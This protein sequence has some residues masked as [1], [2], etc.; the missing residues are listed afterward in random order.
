MMTLSVCHM[1]VEHNTYQ[2]ILKFSL[3][4]EYHTFTIKMELFKINPN[5]DQNLVKTFVKNCDDDP[6]NPNISSLISNKLEYTES[7]NLRQSE[8]L[9]YQFSEIPKMQNQEDPTRRFKITVGKLEMVLTFKNLVRVY[10]FFESFVYNYFILDAAYNIY[11]QQI[12]SHTPPKETMQSIDNSESREIEQ[13]ITEDENNNQNNQELITPKTENKNIVGTDKTK[14]TNGQ[15]NELDI[16]LSLALSKSLKSSAV[17]YIFSYYRYIN[18]DACKVEQDENGIMQVTIPKI[19]P[20]QYVFDKNYFLS[21]VE[22]CLDNEDFSTEKV[23]YVVRK[24]LAT[25]F[26]TN[27]SV[28]ENNICVMTTCYLLFIY[29][30]RYTAD[31]FPPEFKNKF[32]QFVESAHKQTQLFNYFVKYFP[33]LSGYRNKIQF[34]ITELNDQ[35][36]TENTDIITQASEEYKYL[37]SSSEEK[38]ANLVFDFIQDEKQKTHQVNNFRITHSRT[39]DV[40]QIL[41]FNKSNK[42][43][44]QSILF[45]STHL[46]DDKKATYDF[47]E[48]SNGDL[49]TKEYKY[50]KE[51]LNNT[52]SIMMVNDT[53]LTRDIKLL[54]NILSHVT[55]NELTSEDNDLLK[56]YDTI[57]NVLPHPEQI[58]HT[59]ILKILYKVVVPYQYYTYNIHKFNDY[60]LS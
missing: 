42:D 59:T 27:R 36:F 17:H 57:V 8:D 52:S 43:K 47:L 60:F 28:L 40:H 41:Q 21:L 23:D 49:Q 4:R 39:L 31:L 45:E 1:Y 12:S 3:I 44:K 50:F 22:S 33:A 51:Y 19:L 13:T 2:G 54:F 35:Y 6:N 53:D 7:F 20:T 38:F 55:Q 37:K 25:F 15:K 18:N 14:N 29:F 5:G 11:I 16:I 24:L 30:L 56:I 48:F 9:L 32:F 58:E 46:D 34:N 10:R 26:T